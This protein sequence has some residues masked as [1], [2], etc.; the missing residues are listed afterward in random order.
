MTKKPADVIQTV[1]CIALHANKLALEFIPY[2]NFEAV[3]VTDSSRL[4]PVQRYGM[5]NKYIRKVSKSSFRTFGPL[6]HLFCYEYNF[7][8]EKNSD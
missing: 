3:K 4:E 8:Y 1:T 2:A 7:P 6:D 5:Y